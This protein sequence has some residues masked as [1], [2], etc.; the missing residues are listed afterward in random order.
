MR[1]DP[2]D[3]FL[4]AAD[5]HPQDE[6]VTQMGWIVRPAGL[7][8]LLVRLVNDYPVARL[9]ITEN[10]AAYPDNSGDGRVAD[11]ERTRYLAG[12]LEAAASAIEGGVPLVGYFAWSLLDNFEWAWGFT[13]RFGIVHVDFE[14]QRRTVKDS[15]LW[16]REFI[17]AQGQ[18][19][20]HAQPA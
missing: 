2:H 11:P 5:V 20:P 9:A 19:E 15:G 14:T 8:E 4:Q 1:H 13:R 6:Q 16:Y 7:H 12:H 3:P 10:G 18:R 17:G